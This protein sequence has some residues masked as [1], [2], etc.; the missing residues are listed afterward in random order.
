MNMFGRVPKAKDDFNFAT[1]SDFVK[2][3][4]LTA[5]ASGKVEKSHGP[6]LAKLSSCCSKREDWIHKLQDLLKQVSARLLIFIC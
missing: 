1:A 5:F 3:H 6:N 2:K 4:L